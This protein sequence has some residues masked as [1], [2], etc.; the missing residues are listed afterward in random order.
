MFRELICFD[1]CV[2]VCVSSFIRSKQKDSTYQ[3]LS[4]CSIPNYLLFIVLVEQFSGANLMAINFRSN[5]RNQIHFDFVSRFFLLFVQ[6]TF[7]YIWC[8]KLIF[9]LSHNR[10]NYTCPLFL[11]SCC[12][13]RLFILPKFLFSLFSLTLDIVSWV[14]QFLGWN[15][16]FLINQVKI[17][18]FNAKKINW[19]WN[20]VSIALFRVFFRKTMLNSF[21]L[22]H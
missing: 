12:F 18:R 2:C 16:R 20:V 5:Y 17:E 6:P 8:W 19:I 3:M 7:Y 13:R 14:R 4:L 1:E 11:W 22:R 10:L 9:F 21:I 15:N